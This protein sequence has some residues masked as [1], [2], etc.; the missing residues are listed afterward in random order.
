MAVFFMK[1]H[2]NIRFD[3]D[4]KAIQFVFLHKYNDF[5]GFR[6]EFKITVFVSYAVQNTCE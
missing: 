2:L 1:S 4:E 5:L 6:T 3:V